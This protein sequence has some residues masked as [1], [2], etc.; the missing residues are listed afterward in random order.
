MQTNRLFRPIRPALLAVVM[1]ATSRSAPAQATAPANTTPATTQTT[2]QNSITFTLPPSTQPTNVTL[3]VALAASS[4]APDATPAVAQPLTLGTNITANDP[5]QTDAPWCDVTHRMTGWY[6]GSTDQPVTYGPGGYPQSPAFSHCWLYGYP[7][8]IYRL[9]W[10]GG[11]NLAVVGKMLQNIQPDG[12][13]QSAAVTFQSGEMVKFRATGPV[14]NVHL[15]SPDAPPNQTF[16]PAFLDA[17]TKP[18]YKIVRVMPWARCNKD[19]DARVWPTKWSQ[20]VLP[21]DYD[22]TSREVALEYQFQLAKESGAAPWIN[23]YYGEEDDALR[24]TAQLAKTYGFPYIVVESQNEYW[25]QG[26]IYQGNQ[27]RN[28]ALKAG[29]FATGDPNIAGARLAATIGANVGK[30]FRDVLGK[31]HVKVVFGAQATWGAWAKDGLSYVPPGSFDAL[32]VAPYFQP[33]DPIAKGAAIADI[34]AS[35]SKWISTVIDKGLAENYSAA[36]A[37]GVE[38]WTYEGGQHL[39]PLM[40]NA[41]SVPLQDS[42]QARLGFMAD[43]MTV[44]QTDPAIGRLYDQLFATCKKNHVTEFTHFYLLGYWGRSGY[45]GARQ[46]PTDPENPKTQAILRAGS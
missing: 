1:I 32:A 15:Y 8:G 28:D 24:Q 23:T 6:P 33:A 20:R 13:G 39:L 10:E 21:T 45:W 43:P 7:T 31:D 5:W 2:T 4:A 9:H 46:L 16:R 14:A 3:T 40:Q 27:V 29:T 26:A 12:N 44:I 34:E 38:L 41:P 19:S 11:P 25:N 18:G 30:V 42:I 35:C 17:I 36:Q 37:A 22:Q